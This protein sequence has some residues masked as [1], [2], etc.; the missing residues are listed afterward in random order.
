ME[1]KITNQNYC[2][3]YGLETVK[4][5]KFG[6]L[7]DI[8]QNIPLQAEGTIDDHRL[9]FLEALQSTLERTCP[10]CTTGVPSEGIVVRID[11]KEHFNAYK[12]KSKTF[13]KHETDALDK[14]VVD[15]EEEAN[16]A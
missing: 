2:A 15:T 16:N 8:M 5:L 7:R 11:G 10:H 1:L 14:E 4:E 9:Q 12:L 3:K 13:Q 6:K